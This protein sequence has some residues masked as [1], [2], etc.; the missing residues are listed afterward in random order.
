MTEETTQEEPPDPDP[1]TLTFELNGRGSP[2]R[3]FRLEDAFYKGRHFVRKADNP[4]TVYEQIGENV[5]ICF[6]CKG[7]TQEARASRDIRRG[8]VEDPMIQCG[9][10]QYCPKCETL[11]KNNRFPAVDKNELEKAAAEYELTEKAQAQQTI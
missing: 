8:A 11:P 10:V 7:Y 5:Y 9:P 1:R 3:I 4:H 2:K 6:S